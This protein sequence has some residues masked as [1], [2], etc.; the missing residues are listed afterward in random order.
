MSSNGAA[1][2]T[3]GFCLAIPR[4]V[5]AQNRATLGRTRTLSLRRT[6]KQAKIAKNWRCLRGNLVARIECERA[7]AAFQTE[8]RLRAEFERNSSRPVRPFAALIAGFEEERRHYYAQVESEIVQLSLAIAAKILHRERRWI[9][10][11]CRPRKDGRGENARR[12]QRDGSR[13]PVGERVG[14]QYFAGVQA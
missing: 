11:Y 14:K 1:L 5:G 10:C 3:P 4:Y 8:Q 12:F 6:R 9:R 2:P 13:V 7:D